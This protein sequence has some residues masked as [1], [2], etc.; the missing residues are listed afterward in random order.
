LQSK[1]NL[2]QQLYF[3]KISL[4]RFSEFYLLPILQGPS[5]RFQVE[6]YVPLEICFD[7]LE[8]TYMEIVNTFIK[9]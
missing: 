6:E 9:R 3:G 7:E 4:G 2:I 1:V 8:K 5:P